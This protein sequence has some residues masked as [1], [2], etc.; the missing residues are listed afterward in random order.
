MRAPKIELDT[1][2]HTTLSERKAAQR[3]AVEKEAKPDV[4]MFS[5]RVAGS[6]ARRFRAHCKLQK[7]TVQ[8]VLERALS[9]YLE[10]HR[11]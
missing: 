10:R 9:E 1:T 3:A 7:E 2:P 5:A 8:V 11:S 4:E 6:V